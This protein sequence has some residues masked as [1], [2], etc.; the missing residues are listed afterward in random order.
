MTFTQ[1]QRK[2]LTGLLAV[3]ATFAVMA[4]A[5][6]P[7][8][9]HSV[10][11]KGQLSGE[12]CLYSDAFEG[13]T[14]GDPTCRNI[15][16]TLPK[17][18]WKKKHGNHGP[19]L[20]KRYPVLVTFSG[21]NMYRNESTTNALVDLRCPYLSPANQAKYCGYRFD[22]DAIAYDLMDKGPANG[23]TE[24]FIH[25]EVSGLSRYG[26]TRFDCSQI[27]GDMHR[28]VR[29]DLPK[30]IEKRFRV[31]RYDQNDPALRVNRKYWTLSGFSMG[32]GGALFL[33]LKD[34]EDRWGQLLLLSPSNNDL[35]SMTVPDA[36]GRT[37]PALLNLFRLRTGQIPQTNIPVN[38]Q[39]NPTEMLESW[40]TLPLGGKFLAGSVLASYQIPWADPTGSILAIDGITPLYTYNPLTGPNVGDYDQALWDEVRKQGLRQVV[41]RFWKNLIGTVVVVVHGNNKDELDPPAPAP[42]GPV[43]APFQSEPGGQPQLA[44]QLRTLGVLDIEITTPGDHFT[45]LIHTFPAGVREAMSRAGTKTGRPEYDPTMENEYAPC[46]A[47][48]PS[49]ND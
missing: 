25:F 7:A 34:R 31:Y 48:F 36:L 29:D 44:Q 39:S 30:F 27:F 45:S 47:L 5:A 24:E 49:C 15:S 16:Y 32:A 13:N 17:S 37:E 23:G 18:Y 4:M 21:N 20:V 33:K 3:L 28:F 11:K 14:L 41:D 8:M 9:A 38:R 35:S 1:R 40:G 22:Q 46:A 10:P 2:R 26:G 43:N 6:V 42:P 19:Y 12:V